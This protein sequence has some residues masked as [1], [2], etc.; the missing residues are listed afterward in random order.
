LPKPILPFVHRVG[1]YHYFR[2]DLL[3]SV[4]LPGYEGSPEYMAAYQAAMA[5]EEAPQPPIGEARSAPG[6]V[7]AAIALYFQSMAFGSLAASTKQVRRRILDNFRHDYGDKRLA[8]LGRGKVQEL[9]DAK[10]NRPHSAKHFLKALRAVISVAIVAG[11]RADDPTEGV[12]IK[13]PRSSGYRTWSDDEIAQY[14]ARWPI[15]TRERLAFG[16]CLHTGQRRGDV[17]RMG[18]QHIREKYLHVVQQKTGMVLDIPV[19]EPLAEILFTAPPNHMTFLITATGKPF[20]AQ[21]FTAWFRGTIREADLPVG[22]SAHG[23]RKAMCRRLAEAGA[24]ANRIA[25]ISGHT[26]LNEVSR[27]TKGADQ[28]RLAADAMDLLKTRTSVENSKSA[29]GKIGRNTLRI[30]DK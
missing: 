30:K 7:A 29:S 25:A 12:I 27:Y 20:S 10:R 5:G 21:G 15:G 17:I 24:S 8:T 4:R 3:A 19:L 26:T 16:L 28:K 22:L 11:L 23:L 1:K 9:V 18:R 13:L 14:E 2:R 6:S